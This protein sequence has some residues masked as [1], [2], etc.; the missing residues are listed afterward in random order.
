MP[1]ILLPVP[2]EQQRQDADCLAACAAMAL[3]FIELHPD[4]DQLLKLLRV[5]PYGTSGRNLGYL[6][7]LGVEVTYREGSIDELKSYLLDDVPVIALVRTADLSH[8]SYSTD[9][10]VV[11]VG[12]DEQTIYINDPAFET[13][14]IAVP[15]TEFEL[16][17][18]EFDYRYGVIVSKNS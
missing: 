15:M 11:V 9:H 6:V 2:H 3:A 12:F 18:M 8:W 13:H 7:S 10:A 1:N 4:Y 5:K 16:A 17:W 14:P